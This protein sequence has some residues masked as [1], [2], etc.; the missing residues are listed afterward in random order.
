MNKKLLILAPLL[1]IGAFAVMPVAAQADECTEKCPHYYK[2]GAKIGSEPSQR[3][4]QVQ[5]GTITLTSG[6]GPVTCKTVG[7]GYVENPVGE[8]AGRGEIQ[9]LATYECATAECSAE[10]RL[11]T[12]KLPYPEQLSA[13]G[14]TIR[15]K[16]PP[17]FVEEGWLIAGCWT[18]APTGPGN[19]STG[20]R[21]TPISTPL[22]FEGTLEPMI[23]NGPTAGKPTKDVFDK[24]SGELMNDIVG[25]GKISGTVSVLGYKEQEI[26]TAKTP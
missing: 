11:E 3:V 8:G 26:I 13:I 25:G 22:R 2:N 17:P 24:A 4:A 23:N 16:W 15:T 20:E 12:V 10:T 18:G 9:S 7:G 14:E 19:V 21:G 5:W 6:A 1:A